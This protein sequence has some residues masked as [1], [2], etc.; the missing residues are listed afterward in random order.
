VFLIGPFDVIFTKMSFIALRFK[1]EVVVKSPK[2][3]PTKR[4]LGRSE[5]G[6]AKQYVELQKLREEVR[7]AETSFGIRTHSPKG[8][9]RYKHSLH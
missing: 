2:L 5:A 9:T 1:A 6:I 7:Q 3:T 8:A 4:A